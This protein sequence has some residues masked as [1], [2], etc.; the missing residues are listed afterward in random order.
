MSW[1]V[2]VPWQRSQDAMVYKSIVV[3]Q[4]PPAFPRTVYVEKP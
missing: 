2:H 4:E 1:K 3:S